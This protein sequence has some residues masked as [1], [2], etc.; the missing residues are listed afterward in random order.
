MAYSGTVGTTVVNVQ[1]VIDH[2]ARRCGKLAE[3][4]TS[5]QQLTARQSLYYF[6]SSLINIGIQ[7]W[8]IS[9]EVIGLTPDKYI[10]DLPLGA[11]DALNVLYRTMNRPSGQYTSSAGGVVA[12]VYD[13]N[14]STY[15]QQTSPNG[16]ISVFYGTND[17]IYAGSIGILPYVAGG[18]SALWSV[19]Y[20]YSTDNITWNTLDDL[21]QVLVTDNQW[22]WTDI[23]P[24]QNVEY[25]R[26]RVYA[27]TTMALRELYIG[28]NSREL[29]MSRLN[30]DDYTNLPNKNFTA[31][32]PYQF[33]FDRTIPVPQIY[34]WPT[35][36]DAFVQMTVWYSRQIMDVGAL[37]DELE[38]PQRWYE[39][40][41]MNLAHRL[42]L[43]LPQVPMDRVAYLERMAAQYLNEAE[44]EERDK[45][46]IYWAPNISVYTK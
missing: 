12:N 15:C 32:Q 17:P 9:K 39:A 44:Q 42:S 26:V 10:Y 37:T 35:P 3:E 43:E 36:S 21:G 14:T 27:G 11:N 6:L 30:R 5:E 33:W 22:I 25:Y 29:Q 38:I 4:L 24:G 13:G 34:L 1:E 31:N 8:A 7:Y 19:I 45:S 40:I 2:A 28:N 20:E 16:N 18:G 46:P 23:D 41:I